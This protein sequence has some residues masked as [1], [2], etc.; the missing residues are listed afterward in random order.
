M[1]KIGIFIQSSNQELFKNNTE[2]LKEFYHS[3]IFENNLDVDLYSFTSDEKSSYV[4]EDGDTIYCACED[5]NVYRKYYQLMDNI[6]CNKN[7]D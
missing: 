5:W 2:V 7:Y 3:V 4:Y 6:V 1:R